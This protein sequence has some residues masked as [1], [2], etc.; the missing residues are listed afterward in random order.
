MTTLTPQTWA[1]G[2]MTCAGCAASIERGLTKVEGVASASVNVAT[3][4]AT[5]LPDGT[6]DPATLDAAIRAAITGLGYE[7]VD[8]APSAEASH[9]HHAHGGT[10]DDAGTAHH[11]GTA[12]AATSPGGSSA[13]ASE[14]DAHLN[15][16]A[17]RGADLR[18]RFVMAAVLTAP[19]LAISMIPAWQFAG[20]EW[21]AA[22]LGTPVML[23]AGL[24][25]HRS[26]WRSLTHRA[27]QM[28]TLVTLGTLAA[29]TWSMVV[30]LGK[31]LGAEAFMHEHV[32]F[33]TGAVIVTLILLGKWLEVRS[34]SR[35][36]D[37]LRALG[38]RVAATVR[39]A[40]GRD[41][42]REHLAVGDLFLVRPGEAIATDGRI[43]DG[44]AAIDT[45]LITGEPVPISARP[46]M[47]VLGG[48][49][50][51]D[52]ALTVEATR[53]GSETALA[54]IADLVER[55]L[56]GKAR[57]QRLVDR[58]SAIF[59]PTV[60][61]LA[62][63]TAIAW[64]L[65]GNAP[66]KALTSA[67]AVLIISCPCALGL[68]TPLALLVGT[69]R[70][71]QLG[72]L[73]SGP[74][75]MESSR[76]LS[77]IILDKTGTLTEGAMSLVDSTFVSAE[78]ADAE[79]LATAA[80][81]VEARSEHPVAAAITASTDKRLLVKGFRSTPGQGVTATVQGSSVTGD[82]A[83][84]TIGSHRL[85]DEIPAAL[86]TWAHQHE[87]L[88]RTVVY[89]GRTAPVGTGLLG[90]LAGGP[91]TRDRLIAEGAFAVADTI[92]PSAKQAVA[93]LTRLGLD[94]V[95]VTGDNERAARAVA[96]QVGITAVQSQVLPADKASVVQA[97]QASGR[98]V[99]MV[100][101]GVNDSPALAQADVGIAIG[102][103]ADVARE[104]SD[105]T[106]V[107]GDP[108]A[109]ADA[110]ALS[111]RIYGVIRG[112]LFWAFIYNVAAIPLAAFGVLD[113]MIASATMGMSSLFVVGNSLRLKRFTGFRS[114]TR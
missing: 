82:N 24:P 54:Q 92:K 94:V 49:V 58:I 45:S 63:V 114:A 48:T 109:A 3:R 90:G 95:M 2:G 106:L 88:G 101:D 78:S 9:D 21:V 68:A 113:P 18:R 34:T 16:D 13:L 97:F 71:A 30:L 55:A 89:V 91:V 110:I 60:I 31:A 111:H 15:A 104:A 10:S 17:Q 64:L 38:S 35:A 44:Q 65:I 5:V 4:R 20:W 112:N 87:A 27:V 11:A 61:A 6:L 85:F 47:D 57:I 69:G 77:T 37:A 102:T 96:E 12:N 23:W 81:S 53:V 50:V 103:G 107:S 56:N 98:K 25:F 46:G 100:G 32:Y 22:A 84:V 86:V 39:L 42:A 72:I 52:G 108:L 67:V 79:R 75:A 83:D 43:I 26:T 62:V 73:V 76:G 19:L 66:T 74:D 1:V 40:D 41:V 7:V 36:A 28:D 99:A 33:E 105:M 29:W 51:H 14:H 70:G 80:A 8:A 93:A 59:V